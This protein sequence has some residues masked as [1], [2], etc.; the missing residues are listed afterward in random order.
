[1]LSIVYHIFFWVA[2]RG[3]RIKKA[4]RNKGLKVV[5]EE[6]SWILQW[7]PFF[8]MSQTV[9]SSLPELGFTDKGLVDVR[10]GE[11]VDVLVK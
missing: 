2:I 1:M 6:I 5:I 7:K 3:G 10:T 11:I 4:T 8:T 9:L